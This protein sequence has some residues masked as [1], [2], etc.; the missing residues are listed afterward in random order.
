MST[1]SVIDRGLLHLVLT[2]YL[3]AVDLKSGFNFTLFRIL[4]NLTAHTD[5]WPKRES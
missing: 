2:V 4:F 5:E 1:G 3:V